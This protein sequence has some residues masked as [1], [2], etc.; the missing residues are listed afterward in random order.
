[1]NK[2][3]FKEAKAFAF[4]YDVQALAEYINEQATEIL[5][6]DVLAARTIDLVN[7]Q[8]GVKHKEKIKLVDIDVVYQ[9]GTNCEIAASGDVTFSDREIEVKPI[10]IVMK[11][12]NN[13]LRDT[14]AQL[15]LAAGSNEETQ[16]MPAEQIIVNHFLAKHQQQLEQLI[17]KGDTTLLTGNLKFANGFL[18]L[19]AANSASLVDLNPDA[20]TTFTSSNAFNVVYKAFETMPEEVLDNGARIFMGRGF[21]TKLAKNLVDLNYF[22][23]YNPND[24]AS[25]NSFVLPGTDVVVEKVPGLNDVNE[26]YIAK[27][28][29][30]TVGTDLENDFE[31]V[32]LWYEQKD[33]SIYFRVKFKVGTQ[34]P[35]LNQIGRFALATS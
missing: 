4:G 25:L 15:L 11:F 17:W 1:M 21:F 10:A 12:C 20:V 6:K 14:W 5:T 30:L 8:P 7:V 16:N 22:A 19:F 9:D 23:N 13:Q 3:S 29:E 32:T 35:F 31:Q 18:K 33:D 28:S 24:L 34:V 26:F 2:M 27:P